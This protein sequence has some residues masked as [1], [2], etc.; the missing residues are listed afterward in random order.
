[1]S[2]MNNRKSQIDH[3]L[4]N[5]KWKNFLKNCQ[6]YLSFASVGSDNRILSAKLRLSLRSNAA[7]PRKENY[8]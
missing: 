7:T 5:N 3:I 1:M 6:A 2:E 4:I 8:D